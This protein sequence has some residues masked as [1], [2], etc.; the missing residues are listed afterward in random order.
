MHERRRYMSA[1]N[2]PAGEYRWRHGTPPWMGMSDEGADA[3]RDGRE[4][5]EGRERRGRRSGRRGRFGPGGPFAGFPGGPGFGFGA[6][7][8]GPGGPFRP[9]RGRGRRGDVRAALLVLLA[10]EPRNG[11]QLIQEIRDRSGGVWQPSPGSVYPALSQLEDE[12]LVVAEESEGRRT[13]RLTDAGRTYVEERADTLGTP[14]DEV[15]EPFA[16]LMGVREAAAQ[17]AVAIQQV[18]AAGSEEQIERAEHILDD[19]RRAIY[20]ILAEDPSQETRDTQES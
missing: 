6:F 14:W 2:M 5:R 7:G 13:F 1:M 12:G 3:R 10:E 8:P 17:I 9:G 11:Y 16:H 20:R 15:A 19:A 4:G 18:V